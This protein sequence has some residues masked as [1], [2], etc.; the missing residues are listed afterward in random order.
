[1]FV[2]NGIEGTSCYHNAIFVAFWDHAS[3]LKSSTWFW[4]IV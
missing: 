4:T 3:K 2:S 1:V